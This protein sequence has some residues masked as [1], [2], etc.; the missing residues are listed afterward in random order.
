M[1]HCLIAAVLAIVTSAGFA[2]E[3]KMKWV[4]D[5]C[6]RHEDAAALGA[7]TGMMSQLIVGLHSQ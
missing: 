5:A 2:G 4:A 3:G 7:E 6:F 1:R